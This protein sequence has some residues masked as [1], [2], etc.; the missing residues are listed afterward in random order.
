MNK[1][2]R[3]L[4]CTHCDHMLWGAVTPYQQ[5]PPCSCGGRRV[6]DWSGGKAPATDVYG[7]PQMSDASGV[8]HSSQREKV[9]YM[10]DWGYHEA[11]DPV[12]GARKVHKLNGTGFSYPSQGSRRTMREGA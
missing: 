8:E 1:Q 11:G 4:R 7:C 3:D 6:V 9:K 2:S 10:K 5:Y 12:G